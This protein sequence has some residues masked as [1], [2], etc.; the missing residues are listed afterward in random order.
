MPTLKD[1]V[2][3]EPACATYDLP[4]AT[5][6]EQGLPETA[7]HPKAE[8]HHIGLY[9]MASRGAILASEVTGV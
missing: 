6:K 4:M 2:V 9:V 8:T 1:V 5:V 7:A 3:L